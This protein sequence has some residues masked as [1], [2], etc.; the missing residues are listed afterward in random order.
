MCLRR[1]ATCVS[2]DHLRILCLLVLASV[3]KATVRC[4][5]D[6]E[7]DW[8]NALQEALRCALQAKMTSKDQDAS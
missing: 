3:Y 7:C 2:V 5:M 1:G 8:R 6:D 4:R